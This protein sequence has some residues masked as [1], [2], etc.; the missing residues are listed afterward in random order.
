M[1]IE[2]PD[3]ATGAITT[4]ESVGQVELT[5]TLTPTNFTATQLVSLLT[6]ESI[7]SAAGEFLGGQFPTI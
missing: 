7:N 2:G 3:G 5:I 4:D 6:M 1:S